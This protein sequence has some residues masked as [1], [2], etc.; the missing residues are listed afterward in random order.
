MT[1][2]RRVAPLLLLIVAITLLALPT[3][4][5]PLG[6][7]QGEFATIGRG[8]LQGR[9]PY[10]ELWNPK[11]P[12]VFVVYALAM[13]VFGQTSAA[14]R[15]IDLLIVPLI[16][17][18]LYGL[19]AQWR[20]Q[21][22]GLLAAAVFA[23]F[24]FTESFWT[25]TQNDGIALLPMTLAMV[26]AVRAS[27]AF[28]DGANT[29][30]K[31]I[32]FWA[33]LCGGLCAVTLWFKYPFVFFVAAL[34][35]GYLFQPN[36]WQ[37]RRQ[38]A[39]AFAAGG[40]LI[41]VGGMAWLAAGGAFE[42]W[43]ESALVTSGYTAVSLGDGDLGGAIVTALGFRWSQWGLLLVLVALWIVLWAGES[44]KGKG[45]RGKGEGTEVQVDRRLT[46]WFLL[47]LGGALLALVVQAKF[48]DYHWLPLLPPLALLAG[49][50]LKRLG[51]LLAR[52]LAQFSQKFDES[53]VQI[54]GIIIGLTTLALLALM[55]GTIL[56]RT[57]PYLSGAQSQADYYATFRG[58]EFVA[59]ESLQVAE[60]LRARVVPGDSL[61]IWGFRPE[62]YYLS[63]LNPATRFI[64]Q[65]PLVAAWYPQTW[66]DENVEVLWA[67]L[68][69][70]VLILQGDYMPWVTGVDHDSHTLL[71]AYTEL[72]NWL[73]ANYEQEA[74]I[75]NFLIW[76]RRS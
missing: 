21:T 57:L 7:D 14:L 51:D 4:T 40:L 49:D 52:V 41:G 44:R 31:R 72:N 6:R 20:G 27:T 56:S 23:T 61:Y 33:L 30:R 68:P 64:F 13:S 74:Q 75:G 71:Q 66:R 36:T 48:Y 1:S 65:F 50:A 38:A 18:G 11:P 5:Y 47:W 10:V 15:A 22:V 37:T 17:A 16:C 9:V 54:R 3:L 24:Y 76:K 62:V 39:L 2:A 19:G 12:T 59:D 8:L 29:R 26:C 43:I 67:A 60:Y 28:E 63:G 70:Y 53:I 35:L 42:A 46:L 34:V 73:I 55:G 45:E 32:T 58:G 69:P 25:L